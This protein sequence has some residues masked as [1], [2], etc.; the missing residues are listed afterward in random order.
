M[1]FTKEQA[2][3][4]LKGILTNNGKKT[5]R[6]SEKSIT[7]QLETLMPLLAD[8]ETE[9]NDFIEKVKP[10]FEV[11]NSNSEKDQSNFIKDW[12]KNHPTPQKEDDDPD[13]EGKNKDP[14]KKLW[15]RI[16]ELEKKE[17]ERE[18]E[19]QSRKKNK[20]LLSALKEKG[21]DDEDWAKAILEQIE[22]KPDTDVEAKAETLLKLYNKSRS[23]TNHTTP[24]LPNGDDKPKDVFANARAIIKA[25]NKLQEEQKNE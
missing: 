20:E 1:K 5:L 15:E 23:D 10:T 14:M 4:N 6:M 13:D 9:L 3:E 7:K 18:L 24:G 2:F 22:I 8:K 25:R 12:E 19:H 16:E 11:M 17:K 21:V